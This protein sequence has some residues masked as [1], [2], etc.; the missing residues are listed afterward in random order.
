M[1]LNLIATAIPIIVMQLLILP[2]VARKMSE[3]EYGLVVTI[4]AMLNVIP[5]T[6][7]SMLNNIRILRDSQYKE[8]NIEGDFNVLL[9]ILSIINVV[10][11]IF[12]SCF[13]DKEISLIEMILTII[14][15][16]LWLSKEYFVVAFRINIDYLSIAINNLIQ[17]S[18]YIIGYILFLLNGHWQYIY[19]IGYFSSLVYIF[20]KCSLWKERISVTPLFRKTSLQGF[21]LVGAG[22]LNRIVVYADKMI[23]YPVLGG[24]LVAVYF[25]STIFGKVV[26]LVLTPVSSVML[27]YLS[28]VKKRDANIFSMSLRVGVFVCTIGY[29]SCLL[30]SRPILTILYPQYVNLA[31]QY[32]WITTCTAVI[33]ALITIVNPF[34]LRFFDMKWQIFLNGGTA[35]FYLIISLILLKRWELKG[36]CIAALIT[37]LFK[38]LSMI[39]IY[40]N[41]RYF[42]ADKE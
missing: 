33:Y 26:S 5:A 4:T 17:A 16:L 22:L 8:S 27:T 39:L 15:S 9:V 2:L 6:F 38:L 20:M 35:V 11:V 10:L 23:I 13:Y 28:K 7:G 1:L 34:I 14:T 41:H 3:Y 36:F 19:I 25:A 24:E 18:G 12:L 31:M 21:W 29:F 30:I 37:N 42:G 40:R 32:V